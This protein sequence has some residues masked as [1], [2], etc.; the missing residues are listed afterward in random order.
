MK[1]FHIFSVIA[2]VALLCLLVV[3]IGPAQLWRDMA[4]LGW[5]LAPLIAL[6]VVSQ[7]LHTV[8]WRYCLSEPLRSMPFLRLFGIRMSGLAINH[9][10]P[11]AEMGGEVTKGA[12]LS[13]Y[14]SG[15]QA[16]S[17]VI[18][19]KLTYTLAQ[20]FFIGFGSLAV[21]RNVE[22]PAGAL[23]ALLAGS[24]LLGAGVFGFLVVQKYGK[25]GAAARWLAG[26]NIG[27]RVMA[28]AAQK[29]TV[30]DNDLKCFYTERP[31][32]LLLSMLWHVLGL[33]IGIA[34][35]WYFFVLLTGDSRFAVAAGVWMVS[36]WLD[37]LCF[38]IPSNIGVYEGTR[39]LTFKLLS[40]PPSLGLS[41]GITLRLVHL[42]LSIIG[43]GMYAFFMLRASKKKK[44]QADTCMAA[45]QKTE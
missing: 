21:L 37:L 19:G 8:G 35:T 10:T 29:I 38:M 22:L 42:A 28:Q 3:G 5:G 33:A 45:S 4:L 30:V 7:I 32:G 27:G 6:D 34:Q 12:L 24:A 14:H 31:K 41:Y 36:G 9:L 44:V 26:R 17:G 23:P 11:T 15:P 20:L 13:L 18:I 43:L 16:A 2:G 25:L 39:V 1:F 40:L